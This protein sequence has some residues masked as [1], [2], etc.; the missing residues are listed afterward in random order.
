MHITAQDASS[1]QV[2]TLTITD[3][4]TTSIERVATPARRYVAPALIDIQVN[5]YG[6][7]DFNAPTPSAET[8]CRAV[9]A[10]REAGVGLCLPTVTTGGFGQTRRA[11]RAIADACAQDA[12]IAHAVAGIHL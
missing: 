9:V 12:G 3:G 11:L 6:G 7:F 4:V 1:G 8:A 5:G 10:L 2:V